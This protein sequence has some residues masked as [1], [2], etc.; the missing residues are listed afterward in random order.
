MPPGRCLIRL[1]K[2]NVQPRDEKPGGEP[3]LR[4]IVFG[5]TFEEVNEFFYDR[6]W[7]EGLPIVPPTVEKVEHS[8]NSLSVLLM[9]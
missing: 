1:S 8:S 7:S 2:L 9:M 6:E 3:G 5:G 4:D